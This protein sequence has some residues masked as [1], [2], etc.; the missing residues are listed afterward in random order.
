MTNPQFSCH[1]EAPCIC[2]SQQSSDFSSIS[3]EVKSNY[4]CVTNLD[5]DTWYRLVIRRGNVL[6][7]ENVNENTN[8]FVTFQLRLDSSST[9][10]FSQQSI[11]DQWK[12]SEP[13]FE[14]KEVVKV[15]NGNNKESNENFLDFYNDLPCYHLN[16][17]SIKDIHQLKVRFNCASSQFPFRRNLNSPLDAIFRFRIRILNETTGELLT[18]L[19]ARVRVNLFIIKRFLPLLISNLLDHYVTD[20]TALERWRC[21]GE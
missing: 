17:A 20:Q 16:N 10:G 14:V 6:K 12:N 9:G 1:F 2:S 19:A 8:L 4:I 3:S 15:E 5:R 21:S 11:F 7:P 18:D 13:L